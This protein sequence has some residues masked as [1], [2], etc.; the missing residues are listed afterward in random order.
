MNWVLNEDAFDLETSL[1]WGFLDHLLLGTPAAPLRQALES[2]GLGEALTGGGLEDELRQPTWGV[3]LK[4]VKPDNTEKVE[5]LIMGKLEELAREGFSDEAVAA[6]LN[7]IE[8]SLRENNTGRFPRGLS[9][10]LRSVASWLY[11]KD[12]FEPLRFSAP[13]AQ[14]KQRI[15]NK[16]D[17]WRPLLR[18]YLLA[19]KHRVTVELRP[20]NALGKEMEQQEREKCEVKK[21]ALDAKAIEELVESTKALKARRSPADPARP[22]SPRSLFRIYLLTQHRLP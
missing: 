1:A 19:N 4:G 12:A 14:L 7:T 18:Q 20:D 21:G 8:F 2:S 16:E 15:A 22:R 9:L 3:G 6:S 5:A 17:V 11:E 13:L 10:M